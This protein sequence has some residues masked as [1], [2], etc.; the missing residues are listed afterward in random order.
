MTTTAA[1]A[2]TPATER[3][4]HGA[5]FWIIALAFSTELAFCAVPT[6]LYAIYQQ[7]DGFPTI[8]LTIIFGAYA[9]GVMLSLYL[10]G[11]VSDWLGRRRVILGSLLVNLLAAI[12]FLVWNDV[13]GLIVA[14]FISGL[15]IGILTSLFTAFTLTRLIVAYWVRMWRPRTVPI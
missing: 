11:H 4:P 8:V 15:G 2:R 7:R 10:A 14:R 3:L 6:P 13:A 5:G 1:P 12:L 9:V